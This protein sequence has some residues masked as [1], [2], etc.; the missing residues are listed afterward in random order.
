L[1]RD[2]IEVLIERLLIFGLLRGAG[3]PQITVDAGLRTAR[4]RVAE[5]EGEFR[6]I[7][8]ELRTGGHACKRYRGGP[9]AVVGD[10]GV[11]R[12][13]GVRVGAGVG[14]SGGW[15]AYSIYGQIVDGK[16][17]WCLTATGVIALD[18]DKVSPR[19]QCYVRRYVI[20]A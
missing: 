15:S 8:V 16:R 6:E 3:A 5:V 12:G 18:P 2:R 17:I 10:V 1:R 7:H 4:D 19:G 13:Q 14:K 11:C 9:A 20:R